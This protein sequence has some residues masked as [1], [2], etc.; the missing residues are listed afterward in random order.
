MT[1]LKLEELEIK[2]YENKRLDMNGGMGHKAQFA[3]SQYSSRLGNLAGQGFGP[4]D[5][6]TAHAV[7]DELKAQMDKIAETSADIDSMIDDLVRVL[8]VEVLEKEDR[9]AKNI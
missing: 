5:T 7:I 1:Y 8:V 2:G 3:L 9:I 6:S 4:N